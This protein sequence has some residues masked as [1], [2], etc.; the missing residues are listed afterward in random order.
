MT[1]H[2]SPGQSSATVPPCPPLQRTK[3]KRSGLSEPKV[4]GVV[5]HAF[6]DVLHAKQVFS[7][8][9][10][11]LGAIHAGSMGIHAIGQGLAAA[12]GLTAKHA[13]KQVDRLLSNEKIEVW[14]LFDS[15][16][17]CAVGSRPNIVVALDW[18][19]FDADDHSTLALYLVTSHGRATPLLWLTVTK[20]ELKDQRNDHEDR[21]LVKLRE[22]LPP[23]VE[24]LVLADRGFGDKKLFQFLE[25]LEFNYLIRFKGGTFVTNSQGER[26]K[27][28]DWLAPTRH[29]VA[30][31]NPTITAEEVP[32]ETVVC[33]WDRR[34][35]EAWY[36]VSNLA[37]TASQA[38]KRYGRRF[39]IEETFRDIK[40]DRYGMGMS[41]THIG[42]PERR[43]RLFLIATMA[44]YLLTLL[45]AAAES[46]GWD[47]L[48]RAN[49]VR[50]RTHSLFRQG[51]YWYD[52]L[53]Q[54]HPIDRKRLLKI[55]G[56]L[57]AN[58]AFFKEIFGLV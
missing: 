39:T 38:V 19:E 35:K 48:L 40:D 6:G 2:P 3:R 29:A 26:R 18:T 16:V 43:D 15:W 4:R 55:F 58:Q 22:V 9:Q 49:T 10:A 34:M 28:S 25:E 23:D 45:G 53:P 52:A 11:T 20:S 42:S 47:R 17:P 31:K 56:E 1:T 50:R 32:V 37:L 12:Q 7:M 30:L 14:K 5:D 27:A 46:I 21:L 54:L 36:L 41:A 8:S 51:R 13:V 24:V 33:A 44:I 57:I